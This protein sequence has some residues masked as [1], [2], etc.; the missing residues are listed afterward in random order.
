MFFFEGIGEAGLKIKRLVLQVMAATRLGDGS[1]EGYKELQESLQR[2]SASKPYGSFNKDKHP[3]YFLARSLPLPGK[4]RLKLWCEAIGCCL[5][6][7]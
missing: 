5:R 7:L 3:L 2:G 1:E 6:R 4:S